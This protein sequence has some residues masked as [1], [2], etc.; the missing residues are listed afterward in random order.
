MIKIRIFSSFGVQESFPLIFQNAFDLTDFTYKD[1][2]KF[3]TDNT[4]THA[5]LLNTAQQ[6]L[7]KIPRQ[8]VIGLAYEPYEFL[9]FNPQR[10]NYIKNNCSAYYIGSKKQ[11]PNVFKAHY[12]YMT[13]IKNKRNYI[14][15]KDKCMSI[16]F[17]DKKILFGH[18]YRHILVHKILS[19]NLPIDIYGRGCSKLQSKDSRVKGKFIGDT[20]YKGYKFSIAI[21]NVQSTDYIS[22]KFTNCIAISV[23]PIYYGASNVDK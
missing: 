9:H 19:T 10:I 2:F 5:I 18:K 23:V 11:L 4:Y 7:K 6:R 3:V 17:S 12:G 1:H 14:D 20:P 15:S 22:E 21:E 16:I 13:H 8:N